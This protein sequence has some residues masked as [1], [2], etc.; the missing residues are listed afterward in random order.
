MSGGYWNHY[1]G[2]LSLNHCSVVT[3]YGDID[4]VRHCPGKGLLPDD[5]KTLPEAMLTNR[6]SGPMRFI[7]G[8][9]YRKAQDIYN[10]YEF[11]NYY[12]EST[13]ISPRGQWVHSGQYNS[14]RHGTSVDFTCGRPFFIWVADTLKR[15]RVPGPSNDHYMTCH[16]TPETSEILH[17]SQS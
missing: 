14:L 7:C 9:F 12:I 13:T 6:Q 3:P 8:Q 1:P 5:N 2:T 11:E 15:N 16:I 10:W 17:K 4:L